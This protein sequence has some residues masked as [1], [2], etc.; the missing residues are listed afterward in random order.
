MDCSE[1]YDKGFVSVGNKFIIYVNV[2]D[3]LNKFM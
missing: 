3:F 2:C 1:K